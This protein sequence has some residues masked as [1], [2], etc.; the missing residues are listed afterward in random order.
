MRT[1]IAI[2]CAALLGGCA[3]AMK[4]SSP[5]ASSPLLAM[6]ESRHYLQPLGHQHQETAA[7]MAQTMLGAYASR[8]DDAGSCDHGGACSDQRIEVLRELG[9][10]YSRLG[11]HRMSLAIY[12]AVLKQRPEEATS[13]EDAAAEQLFLGRDEDAAR[14]YERALELSHGERGDTIDYAATFSLLT[15]DLARARERFEA[16]IRLGHPARTMQYCA[17]GLA[18][19]K[20]RGGNDSLL[21]AVTPASV[22]PGPLLAYLRGEI[23]E[24]ALVQLISREDADAQREH[25]SEAL[26]HI[27]EQHLAHGERELALRCF[28]ANQA[29]RVEAFFE[30]EASARHIRELGGNEDPPDTI[31]P[32][33]HIPIG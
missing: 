15:G 20:T 7:L 30:T 27:G 28:R 24:A 10:A 12:E 18:V 29:L 31:Q 13:F 6:A 17:I 19:V 23:S 33:S 21:F 22:W 3:A 32:P 9:L 2:V 11:L 26:Y 5:A 14:N 4:S 16:C 25:L 8:E 1:V